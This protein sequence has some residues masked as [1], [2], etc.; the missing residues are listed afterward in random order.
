MDSESNIDSAFKQSIFKNEKINLFLLTILISF[1][2]IFFLGKTDFYT[3]GEPREALVAQSMYNSGNYILP[4]G[5]SG[6]IP[7]KP[8]LLHWFIVLI[9]KI[10]GELNEFSSR[11]PSLIVATIFLLF[12]GNFLF[13]RYGFAKALITVGVTALSFEWSRAA[14]SCRVDMIH[15]ATLALGLILFF[16]YWEKKGI[17]N[18]LF[19]IVTL[20]LSVL[21]KGP[22]A[23]AI[24]TL[25]IGIFCITKNIAIPRI[26]RILFFIF[27]PVAFIASIWYFLAYIEGGER[28]L[29]R[30]SYENL[31]RF[32]ST[33]ED[34][35]HKHGVWYLFV[36]LFAG[37]MP[38]SL[39]FLACNYKKILGFRNINLKVFKERLT[40]L[41][42]KNKIT[43]AAKSNY[44]KFKNLDTFLQ[45]AI[46]CFVLI[47]V[48]Y[49]IPSSKRSVYLLVLYPYF[50]FITTE[51]FLI[52]KEKLMIKL[53]YLIF[54]LNICFHSLIHP[55]I[56]EVESD[57]V[58]ANGLLEY[59]NPSSNIYSYL[60]EFYGVSFY[61]NLPIYSLEKKLAGDKF[62]IDNNSENKLPSRLGFSQKSFSKGDV[63]LL[64]QRNFKTFVENNPGIYFDQKILLRNKYS[65]EADQLNILIL[66]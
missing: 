46:L 19:A 13:K 58:K 1:A 32:T 26:I 57:K 51:F 36:M 45:F 59:L 33:M 21:A 16:I 24:P 64:K 5:Y 11:A 62:N 50:A 4:S 42:D 37:F 38:W 23:I 44:Q 65:K 31:K 54:I 2:P 48:F 14:T 8:P 56:A 66:K 30:I 18:A 43:L 40:Q 39:V 63:I 29:E 47:F 61:L 20:T 35:P 60:T 7:S 3:R 28:F 6:V 15:S 25:I 34:A 49:S 17:L 41:A 22:V 9:S 52:H 27:I 55:L 10:Q 12:F 53:I